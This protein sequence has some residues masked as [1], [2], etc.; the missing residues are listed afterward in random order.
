MAPRP[1][2]VPPV[3]P[4]A[5]AEPRVPLVAPPR[6][7]APRQPRQ[8]QP[9]GYGYGYPPYGYGYAPQRSP[10]R[11][12]YREGDAPPDG[13]RLDTRLRKGFI[14]AGAT[15]FGATYLLSAAI[16]GAFV[17]GDDS[18][19]F[20]PLFVP[21]IGPFIT[22]GT[23]DA[24]AFGTFALVVDGLSQTVGLGMLI[25]G[26]TDEQKIWVRNENAIDVSPLFVR[27]QL[28]GAG[29]RGAF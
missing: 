18:A 21:V 16:A 13:Y 1:G 28:A 8:P 24:T 12:P 11:L 4:G 15:T 2:S 20:S 23:V 9:Y 10:R 7:T 25:F 6:S 26:V 22:T 17:D 3:A 29:L 5:A 19:G 27:G 14:I